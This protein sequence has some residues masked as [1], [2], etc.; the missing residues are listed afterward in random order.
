MEGALSDRITAQVAEREAARLQLQQ[1][2][3][4][5]QPADIRAKLRALFEGATQELKGLR[6]EKAALIA[7]ETALINERAAKTQVKYS[8]VSVKPMFHGV[9]LERSALSDGQQL[10][11]W[12]LNT[13]TGMRKRHRQ[14]EEV[15]Q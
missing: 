13:G 14:P 10:L 9:G 6:D 1:A 2:I 11:D 12:S 8:T 15:P 4:S 5:G 7:R 3:Q